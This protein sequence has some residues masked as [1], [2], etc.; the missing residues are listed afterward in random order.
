MESEVGSGLFCIVYTSF[1]P[2]LSAVEVEKI[3]EE[4]S[5]KNVE[6]SITGVLAFA[7]GEGKVVQLL[8][9]DRNSV[10]NLMER[11]SED[12]RHSQISVIYKSHIGQRAFGQWNMG[13]QEVFTVP[14][15]LV[16]KLNLET[17]NA[18]AGVQSTRA[19]KIFKAFLKEYR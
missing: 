6:K 4:C 9:G 13:F 17:K 16:D 2:N 1:A 3:A 19:V 11:I 5:L 7:G 12:D 10:V 18:S 8:E 15:L 14:K